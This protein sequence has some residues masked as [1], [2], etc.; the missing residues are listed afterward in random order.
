[1]TTIMS[2]AR[3]SQD[4]TEDGGVV[5]RRGVAAGARKKHNLGGGD[6]VLVSACHMRKKMG[7]GRHCSAGIS[8]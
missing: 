7:G 2:P 8:T 6:S 3:V 1:M 5:A 4:L